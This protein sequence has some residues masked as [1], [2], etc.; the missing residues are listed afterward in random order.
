M[1]VQK[2]EP[3]FKSKPQSNPDNSKTPSKDAKGP[4]A[5]PIW[6]HLSCGLLAGTI[7]KTSTCPLDVIKVVL[8]VSSKGGSASE[9]ISKIWREGGLPGFWRGNVAAC[10]RAGPMNSIKFFVNDRLK[11]IVGKGKPLVGGKSF[12]VGSISGLI[13]Q[14]LTYPLDVVR[15]RITVDPKSYT[16]IFQTIFKI[17]QDE[18]VLSLWSGL[19]PTL[20]GVV[21]YDGAQF[22]AYDNLKNYYIQN[23]NNGKNPSPWTTS[24]LGAVSSAFSQ[25]LSFPLDV[26]RKRLMLKDRNGKPRYK[27]TFDALSSIYKKEGFLGLYKGISFN[28]LKAIPYQAV[29]FTA[30]EEIKKAFRN[31]NEAQALKEKGLNSKLPKTKN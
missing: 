7:A 8:Q 3:L 26:V 6:Q 14:A 23:F 10:V 20:L 5:L 30:L 2:K 18:G 27:G 16:G 15:T 11:T 17:V 22:F 1:F 9:T 28:L 4:A 13:A 24:L 21:A 29:Q 25:S 31:Y 12:I 19:E